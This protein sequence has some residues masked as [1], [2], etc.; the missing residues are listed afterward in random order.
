MMLLCAAMPL[1]AQISGFP[2]GANRAEVSWRQFDTEHFT[3][4][5]HDSLDAVAREAASMA[6]AI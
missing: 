2:T 3:I 4:V 5:Y 6:E 1:R